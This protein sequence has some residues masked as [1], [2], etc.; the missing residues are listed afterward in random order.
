L[1]NW[2]AS[3]GGLPLGLIAVVIGLRR[4][5]PA[6]ELRCRRRARRPSPSIAVLPDYE[7]AGGLA[8]R[9]ETT[10][11]TLFNPTRR[12]APP[13]VAE[14][15]KPTIKRGQFTLTG[16]LVVDGKSTAFLR[17]VAGGKSRRSR[18]SINGLWSPR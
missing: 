10:T 11:R 12:P 8:A 18:E 1:L 5:G 9:T 3:P 15:P 7:V 2:A 16:T 14:A 17:E 4:L 6:P 13:V